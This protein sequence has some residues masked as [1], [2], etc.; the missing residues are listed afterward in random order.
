[1]REL[2]YLYAIIALFLISCGQGN[3]PSLTVEEQSEY[4]RKGNFISDTVFKTFSFHLQNSM[5]TGGVEEA[6]RYCNLA[7]YPITDSLSEKYNAVIKRTSLKIRNPLN[8]PDED[9]LKALEHYH[10]KQDTELLPQV[11]LL[12]E[13]TIAY[14]APIKIKPLCLNCHGIPDIH[15]METSADIIKRLYPDDKATGYQMDELRG[16]WSIRF[17]RAVK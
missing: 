12:D 9:E 6:V 14:Y 5:K 11:K 13:K 8:R 4:I 7:A 10:S 1:M 2:K 15:I 17:N 3:L 16:I